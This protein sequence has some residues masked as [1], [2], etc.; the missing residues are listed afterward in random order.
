[1]YFPS[2]LICP[3]R[4]LTCPQEQPRA[5]SREWLRHQTSALKLAFR[6]SGLAKAE[7]ELGELNSM[8]TTTTRQIIDNL[9][10]IKKGAQKHEDATFRSTANC[11]NRIGKYQQIR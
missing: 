2:P 11:V 10:R 7:K 4:L 3:I 9:H 6:S 5:P 1:M 8:F